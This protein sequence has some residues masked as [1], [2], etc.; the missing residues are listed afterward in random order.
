MTQ[1]NLSVYIIIYT[2]RIYQRAQL[3]I[4]IVG[5]LPNILLLLPSSMKV[6]PKVFDIVPPIPL[7]TTQVAQLFVD[8]VIDPVAETHCVVSSMSSLLLW[9]VPPLTLLTV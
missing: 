1:F 4:H 6:K 8:L 3:Y 2:T 7:Q 5:A 9:P